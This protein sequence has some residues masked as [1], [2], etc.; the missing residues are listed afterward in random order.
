MQLDSS[1]PTQQ[2]A[3]VH[4]HIARNLR[5]LKARSRGIFANRAIHET[6]PIAKDATQ[7]QE[8]FKPAI[9]DCQQKS[10]MQECFADSISLAISKYLGPLSISSALL[11]WE[12]PLLLAAELLALGTIRLMHRQSNSEIKLFIF[13]GIGGAAT[14]SALI[15]LGAWKYAA[16]N[17]AGVPLWLPIMWGITGL[18]I[19][20][21]QHVMESA[22]KKELKN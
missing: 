10:R 7:I 8:P 16:P 4:F 18:C 22:G 14:E 2:P 12:R 9:A 15:S 1:L 20:G 17:I 19:I 21:R 11:L 6:Q 5:L 13:C 3:R